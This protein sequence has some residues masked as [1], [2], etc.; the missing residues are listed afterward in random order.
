MNDEEFSR[1]MAAASMAA[2]SS[3]AQARNILRDNGLTT[4][5]ERYGAIQKAMG[6]KLL[7]N[8]AEVVAY[9]AWSLFRMVQ[10]QEWK[11]T[12]RP[13]EGESH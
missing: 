7:S 2:E 12:I 10:D 11:E 5:E 3:A 9:A 4:P 6:Y 13:G 1:S 8:P